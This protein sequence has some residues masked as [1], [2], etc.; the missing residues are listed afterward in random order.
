MS[1]TIEP[2]MFTIDN[3]L[4]TLVHS[5]P[6]C[7]QC[8]NEVEDY[9]GESAS[10][11]TCMVGWDDLGSEDAATPNDPEDGPCGE[12]LEHLP[13]QPYDRLGRHWV[14]GPYQP[15]IL[16]SGH[17]GDHLCPYSVTVTETQVTR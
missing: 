3:R 7:S 6:T 8:G 16:P 11:G 5:Y 12:A 2:Q 14:T 17:T 9:D 10:C 1:T 4:P 15:C 13:S